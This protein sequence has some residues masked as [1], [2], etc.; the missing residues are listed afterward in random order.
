MCRDT[1][2]CC[3]ANMLLM[4]HLLCRLVS[5]LEL[6]NQTNTNLAIPTGQWNVQNN[7]EAALGSKASYL[8]KRDDV[9]VLSTSVC[10]FL[11]FCFRKLRRWCFSSLNQSCLFQ[12]SCLLQ[13]CLSSS[14]PT[15][16][17]PRPTHIP[18]SRIGETHTA[19]KNTHTNSDFLC[20]WKLLSWQ[21]IKIRQN[22]WYSQISWWPI[23]QWW[24]GDATYRG[25]SY[26]MESTYIGVWWRM[27][28]GWQSSL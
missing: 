10:V 1:Q 20:D 9:R 6:H 19:H 21:W 4:V 26:T 22:I 18:L 16:T 2:S 13:S 14:K 12:S 27:T 25:E 28:A 17:T 5:R 3:S 15:Y 11:C 23:Y 8:L 24:L 7:T